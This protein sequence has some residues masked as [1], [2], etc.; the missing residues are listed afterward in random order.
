VTP[1]GPLT[2]V[3]LDWDAAAR[4]P[5]RTSGILLGNRSVA[6]GSPDAPT[7]VHARLFRRPGTRIV[8]AAGLG[9]AQLLAIRAAAS[10]ATL[11]I[12]TDRAEAWRA[13]LAEW[14]GRVLI[15]ARIAPDL[16]SSFTHPVLFVDDSPA[17]SGALAATSA[18]PP[19]ISDPVVSGA[20]AV[21]PVQAAQ[22]TQSALGEA[23]SWQCRLLIREIRTAQDLQ[24]LAAAD[25]ILLGHLPGDLAIAAGTALGLGA[26]GAQ[27]AE[28]AG[29]RV[30][31]VRSR[32]VSFVTVAPTEAE[33]RALSS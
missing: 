21:Q 5:T 30:A 19:S 10:G 31:L 7:A 2:R 11:V 25:L 20:H 32:T 6:A 16:P 12:R 17:G 1:V 9:A 22:P 4:I 8:C 18:G 24:P 29:G 3:R 26:A 14:A 33:R 15:E 23:R 27:L 28:L 13:P